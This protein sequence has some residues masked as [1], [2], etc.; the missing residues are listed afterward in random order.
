LSPNNII[1]NSNAPPDEPALYLV[2]FDAFVAPAAGANRDICVAEGGTFGTEGYCP[3]DLGTRAARGDSSVAPYS[4]RYGRDMLTLELL[5]MHPLLS[6]DDPP[7]KWNPVVLDRLYGAWRAACDPA[8][9]Q[10]LA[11]LDVPAVFSL[12]EAGRPTSMQ[13]AEGLGI[14]LPESPMLC[15]DEQLSAAIPGFRSVSA[16]VRKQRRRRPAPSRVGKQSRQAAPSRVPSLNQWMSSAQV[17][18]R[19]YRRMRR[20]TRPSVP[21]DDLGTIIATVLF[22]ALIWSAIFFIPMSSCEGPRGSSRQRRIEVNVPNGQYS[23]H[24]VVRPAND[25]DLPGISWIGAEV[26]MVRT[27]ATNDDGW[28]VAS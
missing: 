27:R 18:P 2:D 13:V 25:L 22:M 20:P 1:I 5:L 16:H 28:T 19:T 17:V 15:T 8:R 12:S 7:A 3:A 6:P 14:E 4:D 11:H 10:T 24:L 26:R 23:R 9:R 21:R